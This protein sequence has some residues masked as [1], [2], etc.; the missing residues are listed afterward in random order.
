MSAQLELVQLAK[1]N[2]D[3]P[4]ELEA[5]FARQR[6][7]RP[8]EGEQNFEPTDDAV[9]KIIV[10]NKSHYFAKDVKALTWITAVTPQGAAVPLNNL[11]IIP[12]GL[13]GQFNL[14]PSPSGEPGV[15][16]EDLDPIDH[17]LNLE[18]FLRNAKEHK[19][20]TPNVDY[21]QLLYRCNV[22]RFGDI[23]AGQTK[24]SCL[25]IISEGAPEN[26]KYTIH[27]FF[28]FDCCKLV[29]VPVPV[30]RQVEYG[31]IAGEVVKDD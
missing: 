7:A 17:D 13:L 3:C 8:E 4:C 6:N 1:P 27:M 23:P 22:I 28:K 9:Y 26:T 30:C 19:L 5:R 18:I 24:V 11:R 15:F 16:P 25:T 31:E 12:H 14:K 2:P 21:K 20:P 10:T 29:Q